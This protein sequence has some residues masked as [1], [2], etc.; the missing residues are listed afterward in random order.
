MSV[1]AVYPFVLLA[2]SKSV[3]GCFPNTDFVVSVLHG[4]LPSQLP[5]FLVK[6]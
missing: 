1:P 6:L 4:W 5:P 3:P 2:F